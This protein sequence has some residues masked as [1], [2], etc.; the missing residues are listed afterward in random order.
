MTKY[1]SARDF[2]KEEEIIIDLFLEEVRAR[3]MSTDTGW[4]APWLLSDIHDTSW[5]LRTGLAAAVDARHRG[6]QV[7]WDDRLPNG[8]TLSDD[9]NTLYR[10]LLQKTAFLLRENSSLTVR[11]VNTH[12]I[13]I[14]NLKTITQFVFRFPDKFAP[15]TSYLSNV[16]NRNFRELLEQ[17]SKGS[18]F[19]AGGYAERFLESID[20]HKLIFQSVSN[21]D[22]NADVNRLPHEYV[23]TLI[24]LLRERGFYRATGAFGCNAFLEH[25]SRKKLAALLNCDVSVFHSQRAIAFFRQFEPDYIEKFGDLCVRIAPLYR[26][27][28]SHRT[29]MRDEILTSKAAEFSVAHLTSTIE[30]VSLLKSRLGDVVP[31]ISAQQFQ[32][33]GRF[34]STKSQPMG[35]TPW[36]P[37]D[38]AMAYL[39]E[40]IKWVLV[41]GPILVDIYIRGLEFFDS[42]G[43]QALGTDL[44]R[45]TREDWFACNLP[46]DLA[47]LNISGWGPSAGDAEELGTQR[48]FGVSNAMHVLLGACL[49]VIAG[50][51]PSR[52]TEIAFLAKDCVSFVQGDGYWLEKMRG[53]AVQDD[54]YDSH[55]IPIPRILSKAIKLLK[56]IG[57]KTKSFAHD[58]DNSLNQYLLYLPDFFSVDRLGFSKKNVSHINY[59][60]N[61]FCDFVGLPTDEHGRRWYVRVHENRKSFLLTLIWSFKYAALD[62][63]R[64]L[65]GHSNEGF[66]ISYMLRAFPNI[67]I[68]ELEANHLAKSLWNF[69]ISP[70]EKPDILNVDDLYGRVCKHFNVREISEIEP[71]QLQD[72]LELCI[73]SGDY[74]VELVEI[75]SNARKHRVAVRVRFKSK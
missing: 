29:K 73:V 32:S 68:S 30:A 34:F 39:N 17:Y 23:G 22:A 28:P 59:A 45:R 36:M 69:S 67:A 16:D 38:V 55:R 52:V 6:E 10:H 56:D 40:S 26:D 62:T 21:A 49:H 4:K 64:W 66:I 2:H 46:P 41:Y 70:K 71:E 8:T 20:P 72:W 65:A 51:A 58:Y 19:L 48:H 63:A 25:I 27:F 11:S 57:E 35:N 53:K 13:H 1:R 75:N 47:P 74:F 3:R 61:K 14:S 15:E 43:T 7:N 50:L 12:L 24:G 18:L 54:E 37:I 42:A 9:C 44:G 31:N 5:K 60:L 33:A